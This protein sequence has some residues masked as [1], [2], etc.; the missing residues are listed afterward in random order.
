M[1]PGRQAAAK[2]DTAATAPDAPSAVGAPRRGRRRTL[3]VA[4]AACSVAGLLGAGALFLRPRSEVEP[5]V[6]SPLEIIA[7]AEREVL[8]VEG[9]ELTTLPALP[10]VDREIRRR[11][12]M[13][14]VR[15]HLLAD[16]P[17]DAMTLID[18]EELAR[19]VDL[20]SA[21][22]SLR[23][24][25]L[26]A[27]GRHAQASAECEAWRASLAEEHPDRAWACAE[28]ALDRAL[29]GDVTAAESESAPWLG[30]SLSPVPASRLRLVEALVRSERGDHAVAA[31]AL[32]SA[33]TLDRSIEPRAALGRG[34]LLAIAGD[35]GAAA[36]AAGETG[37]ALALHERALDLAGGTKHRTDLLERYA[38]LCH[39]DALAAIARAG[40]RTAELDAE[41]V[42]RRLLAAAKA[43]HEF[44]ARLWTDA[45]GDAPG[46]RNAALH[47]AAECWERAG[48]G[49]EAVSAWREWL[50]AR[51]DSDPQRAQVLWRVA[52]TL[53]GLGRFSEAAEAW[54]QLLK[55]HPNSPHAA[56]APV[57]AARA[58]RAIGRESDAALLLDGVLEGRGGIDPESPAYTAALVERGRVAHAMGDAPTARRRLEEALRRAPF[59]EDGIDLSLLL[60]DSWRLE[61]LAA[62]A[63][64]AAPGAP[65]EIAAAQASCRASWTAAAEIF[66]RTAARLDG[67]AGDADSGYDAE[68]GAFARLGLAS[69]LEAL[70]RFDEASLAYEETDRRHSDLE[71]AL[72]AL[73]RLRSMPGVDAEAVR[74][75]ALRRIDGLADGM[76]LLSPEA[77]RRWFAGA[78]SQEEPSPM[79]ATPP[80][81]ERGQG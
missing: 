65:S 51:P 43:A 2:A 78:D 5:V 56:Q 14:R 29:D 46:R 74:R 9:A 13:V 80:L 31:A 62:A 48:R 6:R 53:H 10:G 69:S 17:E 12:V 59:H 44:A 79:T 52:E 39:D 60:A 11:H 27:A 47:L 71:A 8:E 54:R 57:A 40:G 21:W 33:V 45:S 15:R 26:R 58:L 16:A 24:R 3:V 49:D 28:V 38:G 63:R 55:I 70:G 77:W 67:R 75:R 64:A 20:D 41:R 19:A 23:F 72:V 4:V 73:D 76:R 18:F 36:A 35:L 7:D 50:A 81:A 30:R 1:P 22:L 32:E 37:P 34:A 66:A 68:R 25:A 42:N 61:A